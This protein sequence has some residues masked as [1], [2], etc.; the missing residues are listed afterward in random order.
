MNSP[1]FDSEYD[2]IIVGAALAG[3]SAALELAK[4][5]KKILILEQHNLPGGVA[6]SYVRGG[7][8]FEA[9]LHEMMCIGEKDNPLACRAFLESHGVDVDWVRIP[10]A[11]RYIDDEI[12]TVI[13]S[14]QNGD[15]ETPSKDIA[16][17]CGENE[18]GGPIYAKVLDFLKL[19]QRIDASCDDVQ[20]HKRSLA[21]IALHHSELAATAG[22]SAKE[23]MD[24]YDLPKKAVDLLSAYWVYLGNPASRLPFCVY[25]VV[26]AQY[27]GNGAYIPRHTSFEMSLKMA[28]RAREDGVQIEYR[29]RVEKILINEKGVVYGVRTASGAEIHAKHI[30]CGAYPNTVYSKMLEEGIKVP[31]RILKAAHAK[32]LSVSAFSVVLL[33]D[34]SPEEL[35]IKDYATFLYVDKGRDEEAYEKGKGE[36]PYSY[37]ACICPNIVLPD[38]CPEGETVYSLT[39][40]PNGEAFAGVNEQNYGEISRKNATF[41]IEQA[42]K[43]LGV[44]LFDHI[45]EITLE[46]PITIAHYAGSYL[47]TIYGYLHDMDAHIVARIMHPEFESSFPGLYFIGAHHLDGDGMAPV[48]NSGRHVARDVLEAERRGKR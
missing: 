8:E 18:E 2:V 38:C 28:E 6:T 21:Y 41:F 13:R 5:G 22:Y 33:L 40:L 35:G 36:G 9:S 32:K 44:N 31:Q 20:N 48:I 42:S 46:T 25:A 24:A 37:I 47:G 43:M 34:K 10:D 27:L 12:D 26:L 17:A 16:K 4:A 29:Q 23:V 7:V 14:G 15:V 19:C 3:L 1:Y 39:Y 45:Q 11:Y 30:L